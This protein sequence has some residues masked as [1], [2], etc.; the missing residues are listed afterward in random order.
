MISRFRSVVRS[1]YRRAMKM[2]PSRGAHAARL[3]NSAHLSRPLACLVICLI[4]LSVPANAKVRNVLT[5]GAVGDGVHNDTVAVLAAISRLQPGDILL[6]PCTNTNS[7]YVIT[8]Q[9]NINVSHVTVDGSGCATLLDT[10]TPSLGTGLV[11]VIGGGPAGNGN[12]IYGP[13][14][15]LIETA[16]ELSNSFTTVTPLGVGPGDYVRLEEGGKDGSEGNGDTS[17]DPSGCRSELLKVAA[18]SGNTVTVTTKLHDTFNPFVNAA[19]A[20]QMMSPLWGITVRDI[21]FD[22]N[23]TNTYGLSLAGVVD[24]RVSNVTARNVLGSA[25][26][27]RG[28]FNVS[29]RKLTVTQAGSEECGS[30][31]WFE[32]QED[33]SISDLS[34]YNENPGEYTNNCIGDGAFGF[35]LLGSAN[36]TISNLT[37][38]ATGA[39]GR[40][41]KTTAARWNTFNF[42][43]AENADVS[44]FNGISLEYYSSHNTYNDCHVTNNG[45]SGVQTG[46][47]GI[48]SF[49]NFNQ[50]NTFNDCIVTGNGNV[51]LFVSGYDALML[52][53]DSH[54]TI[55]GGVYTG[56]N[57]VE[58]PILIEGDSATI[59]GARFNGPGPVGL[60]LDVQATNAC[61]D[62]NVFT[63]GTGLEGAISVNSTNDRGFGNF[64]NGLSSDLPYGICP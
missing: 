13:A 30:A 53:Q 7:T 21:T 24:S 45:T 20:Q 36:N 61:A 29:W 48:N 54:V 2:I 63:P 3:S 10:N 56:T 11:M 15:E 23:G 32:N 27:N 26:L 50:Y 16:N 6:F 17:C 41:F 49:G 34:I 5:Y 8:E 43:T 1:I 62:L 57:E 4:S 28:D 25:L 60:Y 59:I 46:S 55:R 35:E 14:V 42:V 12:P 38:N 47:A 33:S 64:L 31:A 9:V 58:P 51:Q 37:V 39:Y 19:V 52:A 40:P 22:G 44:D 18:V